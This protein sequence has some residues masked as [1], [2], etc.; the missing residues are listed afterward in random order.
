MYCTHYIIADVRLEMIGVDNEPHWNDVE[1]WLRC[2]DTHEY[3]VWHTYKSVLYH[4]R[5]IDEAL[6]LFH[7]LIDE[8]KECMTEVSK[9]ITNEKGLKS[10]VSV[11]FKTNYNEVA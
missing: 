2:Y 5:D 4:G 10:S 9:Y 6:K 8:E 3:E 1:V 7:S 11:E